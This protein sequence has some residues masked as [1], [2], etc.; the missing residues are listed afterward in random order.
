MKAGWSPTGS[1]K[2]LRDFWRRR[3]SLL[4]FLMPETS[5][6]SSA[7]MQSTRLIGLACGVNINSA[8]F[9]LR[10]K[11]EGSFWWFYKSWRTNWS[12]YLVEIKFKNVN[13]YVFCLSYYRRFVFVFLNFLNIEILGD[14]PKDNHQLLLLRRDFL[15]ILEDLCKDNHQLLLFRRA[16]CHPAATRP[17]LG[18]TKK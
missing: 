6:L 1:Q 5:T 3:R 2:I 16:G 15:M 10:R 7:I 11:Y 8:I 17:A 14:L 12:L 4:N 13:I 9:V 18:E